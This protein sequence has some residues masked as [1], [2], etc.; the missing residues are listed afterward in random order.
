MPLRDDLQ[1]PQLFW[2]LTLNLDHEV[3]LFCGSQFWQE[4]NF[5]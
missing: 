4:K 2:G 5:T 1:A 3:H